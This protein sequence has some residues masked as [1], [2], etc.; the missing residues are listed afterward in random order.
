S[1]KRNLSP[2]VSKLCDELAGNPRSV[3][4]SYAW[5]DA[6]VKR[7]AARLCQDLKAHRFQAVLDQE[8]N[9]EVWEVLALLAHCQNVVVLNDVHYAESAL[10]GKVPVTRPSSRYP[11]FALPVAGMQSEHSVSEVY[12][13][14]TITW[15]IAN[16]LKD[17]GDELADFAFQVAQPDAFEKVPGLR[18]FV[19]GWRVDE[20]QMVF[21]NIKGFRSLSVIYLGG[22]NCLAGYPLF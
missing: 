18:L 8:Q 9:L 11:S 21:S 3:F 22:D 16:R 1:L 12:K 15:E 13:I 7:F 17:K 6:A 2:A 19:E 4:I 10:L 20:I 5:S 14:A